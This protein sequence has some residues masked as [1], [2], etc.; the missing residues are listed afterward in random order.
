MAFEKLA[1]QALEHPKNVPK[2]NFRPWSIFWK[3]KSTLYH[4]KSL[5]YL[6]KLLGFFCPL[7]VVYKKSKK[8][9]QLE[10]EYINEFLPH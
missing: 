8:F 1:L 9:G 5:R 3:K 10:S 2:K 6:K 4:K 7:T